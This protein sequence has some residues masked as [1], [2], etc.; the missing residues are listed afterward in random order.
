MTFNFSIPAAMTT[1]LI[2]LSAVGA[3]AD[4]VTEALYGVTVEDAIVWPASVGE[5]ARLEFRI[6]NTS[7]TSLALIGA[8]APLADE[9]VLMLRGLDGTFRE[10]PQLS[11][12]ANEE[13]DL[14]SSHAWVALRGL[15]EP[16][17]EGDTFAF[18]LIFREG[19]A[20]AYAHVHTR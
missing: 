2:A 1:I 17:T 13:L 10:V 4:E 12:L 11:I 9:A 18:D 20:S 6:D 8:S 14:R 5:T 3:S 15:N 16:L 19:R 7:A